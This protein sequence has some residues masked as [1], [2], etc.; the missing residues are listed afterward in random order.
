M[1]NVMII[2]ASPRKN[3]NSDIL[4]TNFKNGALAAGHN[5]EKIDLRDKNI[6]YCIGCYACTKLGKCFQNDDM[7]ELAKKLENADVIVLATPVYFYSMDAQLKTFID[8]TVQ[9]YTKIRADIYIMATAWDPNTANLESTVEAVRGF[10]RDCLEE[11]PEK[12]VIIAG[13]VSEKGDINK[14]KYP[15]QA[16]NMG[17]NC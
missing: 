8:R 12:G 10:S 6:G 16:Y 11:C 17:L 1:K 7:N 2:S 9:N 14:T 13:G 5:V 3:G 15:E 4:C